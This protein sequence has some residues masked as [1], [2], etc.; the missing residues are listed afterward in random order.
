MLKKFFYFSLKSSNYSGKH[1]GVGSSGSIYLG[2]WCALPNSSSKHCR[3]NCTK[4]SWLSALALVLFPFFGL[5]PLQGLLLSIFQNFLVFCI[6]HFSQIF[7]IFF[8]TSFWFLNYIFYLLLCLFV[9][10]FLLVWS[11]Y[12]DFFFPFISSF[13]LNSVTSLVKFSN[14][15]EWCSFMFLSFS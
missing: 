1:P 3:K 13:L 5:L 2:T 11:F 14:S 15:N 10:L 4:F 8:F 6:C 7:F 9:P 12:N